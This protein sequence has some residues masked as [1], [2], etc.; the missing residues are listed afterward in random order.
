M[1]SKNLWRRVLGSVLTLSDLV[2]AIFA[3]F[4]GMNMFNINVP[5]AVGTLLGGTIVLVLSIGLWTGNRYMQITRIAIYLCGLVVAA[6]SFSVIGL[7]KG[8]SAR[9]AYAS[10]PSSVPLRVLSFI[11][12][13]RVRVYSQPH[14]QSA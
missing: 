9:V 1:N 8:I 12:T 4:G 13:V 10:D 5:A 2:V 7:A 3:F 11:S 14:A 6:L